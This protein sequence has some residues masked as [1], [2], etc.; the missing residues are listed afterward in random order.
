MLALQRAIAPPFCVPWRWTRSYGTIGR[1]TFCITHPAWSPVSGC[2]ECWGAGS[3]PEIQPEQ[4]DGRVPAL[5]L[6][7]GV[8]PVHMLYVRR[9]RLSHA[10]VE[11][12][13]QVPRR[14]RESEPD[15]CATGGRT[16]LGS[17]VTDRMLFGG[18]W[19]RRRDLFLFL[20]VRCR[21]STLVFV[22]PIRAA[23]LRSP[24][25]WQ[26]GIEW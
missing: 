24:H 20:P 13:A 8:L 9:P 14:P 1:N 11:V 2:F 5:N 15:E 12:R 25:E 17:R 3:V 6:G 26:S 10:A 18:R 7:L 19:T 22:S 16:R 23:R 21:Q 4:A